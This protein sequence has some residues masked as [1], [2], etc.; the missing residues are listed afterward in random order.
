MNLFPIA[1]SDM[2]VII[3]IIAVVGWILSQI[4]GKKKV[5]P[6]HPEGS[7][8]DSGPALDPR[9]E[10]RKFFD[11]LEKTAPPAAAPPP[12]AP[13]PLQQKLPRENAVRRTMESR[14]ETLSSQQRPIA[15]PVESRQAYPV[16]IE[17]LFSSRTTGRPTYP[18][19]RPELRNPAALRKFIIV[20]EILGKPIALRQ[21]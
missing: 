13:P 6:S 7:T 8:P 21:G 16:M 17:P 15:S 12:V 4:F 19:T 1:A 10:L 3:G 11:E 5:D 20:N 14:G 18:A 2:D 9:D